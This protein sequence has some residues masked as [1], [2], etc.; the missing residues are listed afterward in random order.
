MPLSIGIERKEFIS[1]LY[2]LELAIIITNNIK[3]WEWQ[4]G[5]YPFSLSDSPLSFYLCVQCFSVDTV[6]VSIIRI[7]IRCL[8]IGFWQLD[9]SFNNHGLVSLILSLFYYLPL[10]FLF[11]FLTSIRLPVLAATILYWYC[12]LSPYFT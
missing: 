2:W 6:V 10:T 12:L 11:S 7:V 1:C 5:I 8:N 3:Y 9:Y 4:K